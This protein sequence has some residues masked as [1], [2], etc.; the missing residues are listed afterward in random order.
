[1][2]HVSI[3]NSTYIVVDWYAISLYVV[4]RSIIGV[5][6]GLVSQSRHPLIK[7]VIF[8]VHATDN[9]VASF[10]QTRERCSLRYLVPVRV[11]YQKDSGTSITLQS[12]NV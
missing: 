12:N 7:S 1:M 6:D 5:R 4:I 9:T 10:L 3:R 2:Y 11:Y 8:I